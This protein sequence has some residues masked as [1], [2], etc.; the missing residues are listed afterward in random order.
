M[1]DNP[2]KL[3]R[4]WAPLQII[5]CLCIYLTAKLFAVGQAQVE[6]FIAQVFSEVVVN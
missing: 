6:Q 3:K 1:M 4:S 5:T 2:L